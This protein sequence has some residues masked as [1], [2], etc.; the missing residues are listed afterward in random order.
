[1]KSFASLISL[2]HPTPYAAMKIPKRGTKFSQR[3]TS[4]RRKRIRNAA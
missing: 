1:M 2:L 4:F 3:W